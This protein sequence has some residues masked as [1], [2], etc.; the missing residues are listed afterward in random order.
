VIEE[1]KRMAY[2]RR[3]S[4]TQT[5]RGLRPRFFR[6]RKVCR[7]CVKKDL[8]IDY[9]DVA[10]LRNYISGRG[11]IKPRRFTGTCARHQ[12]ELTRAIKRAR[13]IALLPFKGD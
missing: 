4:S 13:S 11:K 8:I 2:Q 10:T 1:E 5:R 6:R 3:E 12:R 9:K 7:F